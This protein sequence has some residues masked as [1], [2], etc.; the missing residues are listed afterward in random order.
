MAE[1]NH[2]CWPAL[3]VIAGIISLIFLVAFLIGLAFG[4]EN[5]I[6]KVAT[7]MLVDVGSKILGLI[8]VFFL[9]LVISALK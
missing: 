5:L 9:I 3:S 4:N 6:P 7:I 2:G 1:K 8:G